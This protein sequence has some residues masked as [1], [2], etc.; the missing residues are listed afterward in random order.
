MCQ[1]RSREACELCGN[2]SCGGEFSTQSAIGLSHKS[3]DISALRMP[4]SLSISCMQ[5]CSR[6][7]YAHNYTSHSGGD[8]LNVHRWLRV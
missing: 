7:P 3:S 8:W 1:N 2:G 6:A 4:S 5:V